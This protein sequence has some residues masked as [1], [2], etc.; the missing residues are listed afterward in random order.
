MKKNLTF[1]Q[2]WI[3]FYQIRFLPWRMPMAKIFSLNHIS[4]LAIALVASAPSLVAQSVTTSAMSGT[5]R[6]AQ[7][8][9]VAGATVRAS[10]PALIIGER[11]TKTSDNGQYRFPLLPPGRYKVTVEA[12]GYNTATG[13]Y[14]LE[15]NRTQTINWKLTDVAGM[16]VEITGETASMEATPVGVTRNYSTEEIAQLPTERNM[17]AI[18]NLTPGINARAAWGG[19]FRDNAYMMDGINIGDSQNN[20]QWIYPNLDWFEEVQVGGIGAPAEFGGFTGSFVNGLLK[21]GGNDFS[22]VFSAYWEDNKWEALPTISHPGW[23]KV[24]KLEPAKDWDVTFSIG[25]PIIKDKVWFFVSTEKKSLEYAPIGAVTNTKRDETR[26]LSKVT[27]QVT[28]MGTL[29][30]LFEWDDLL[31]QR[32]Y[33][34]NETRPEATSKE[35]SV[36]RSYGL[37][38]MQTIGSDKVLTLKGFG[39]AGDYGHYAYNG[40]HPGLR[41]RGGLIDGFRLFHNARWQDYNRR[42]R[43]TL[44]ASFDWFKTGLFTANDSH[45]FRFG[46]DHEWIDHDELEWI[47]GGYN[48]NGTVTGGQAFT[49]WFGVGGGYNISVHGKRLSAYAQD[50]WTVNDFVTLRPGL[51]FENQKGNAAGMPDTWGTSTVAPRFGATVALTKDMKNVFKFH[52]GRYYTAFVSAFIDRQYEHMVPTEYEYWWHQGT[53]IDPYNPSTWPSWDINNPNNPLDVVSNRVVK[54]D[55]NAKQPYMDE[56]VLSYERKLG[57]LW[58]A[59]GTYTYRVRKDS[60]MQHNLAQDDG[61]WTTTTVSDY[62]TGTRQ[63]LELHVWYPIVA[64]TDY[65]SK[66]TP[67]AKRDY[68]S[69]T[70]QVSRRFRDGWNLNASYTRARSYGNHT[71]N[72][73]YDDFFTSP[74]YQI[75][76]HGLLPGFNDD[77][78]KLHGM[79]ELPWKSTRIS[80]SFIYLSGQHW[81]PLTYLESWGA[82]GSAMRANYTINAEPLGSRTYPATKFLD[83]RV[84]QVVRFNKKIKA[85]FFIDFFN[86]LNDTPVYSLNRWTDEAEFMT[87][88]ELERGRRVRLG[89]RTTF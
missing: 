40:D 4:A 25:G 62:R 17:V 59:T 43:D 52:W 86:L 64:A 32:R 38:W 84:T 70:L 71:R 14:T 74:N 23:E 82:A 69:A 49:N 85:D 53:L 9:P 78:F 81:T 20:N 34:D 11:A 65:I 63:P 16:T 28:Q 10:S 55:P 36:N 48:L 12:P 72:Y 31:H 75:N 66:N 83:F 37:T 13:N 56:L 24:T 39:F 7:G 15:L 67:E 41:L 21:R 57:D 3:F 44:S 51:R 27:W 2:K 29:E 33:L 47:T 46:I 22:G 42:G 8:Q 54:T 58:T 30:A 50:V 87:T 19:T 88:T 77:E 18:M 89:F 73:G 6:N 61:Y 76:F 26:F 5:V 68:W 45:A 35:I 60:L 80:A 1:C 79:Y